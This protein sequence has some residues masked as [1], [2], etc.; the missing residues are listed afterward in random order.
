MDLVPRSFGD[1]SQLNMTPMIDIV[2]QL[3]LF[4][5]F[6]L[7]F[8]SIDWRIESQL[9]DKL[10]IDVG[11]P[12][13]LPTLKAS[14]TRIDPEDAVHA[15]TQ[16]KIAGETWILA[17]HPA[18]AGPSRTEVLS[19]IEARLRTLYLATHLPGAIEAKP[20]RGGLVPHEDVVGVL[21]A[22]IGAEVPEV[23]FEG[24]APPLSR[25]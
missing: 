19:R 10:G 20:P 16:V 7:R 9:P 5:L 13:D 8:K 11:P 23:M 4:F 21:D 17:D 6:S 3:I 24:A 18:A 14:L 15:R 12:V 2:F 1:E 22:F 25:R